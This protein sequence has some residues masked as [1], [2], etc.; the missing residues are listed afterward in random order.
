M[1][2]LEFND[3]FKDKKRMSL[4]VV[5]GGVVV[6]GWLSFVMLLLVVF[7]FWVGGVC[8]IRGKR[9]MRLIIMIK[10]FGFD[11]MCGW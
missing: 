8:K 4:W 9:D 6:E 10:K 5:K 3:E 1:F 2:K 11:R 7:S